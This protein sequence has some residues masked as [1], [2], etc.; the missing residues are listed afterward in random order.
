MSYARAQAGPSK[1]FYDDDVVDISGSGFKKSIPDLPKVVGDFQVVNGGDLSTLAYLILQIVK[2]SDKVVIIRAIASAVGWILND[3]INYTGSDT[4]PE[5]IT[6]LEHVFADDKKNSPE[7]LVKTN[8]ADEEPVSY[9][10]I[11]T[12]LNA[13]DDEMGSFIGLLFLAGVKQITAQNRTAFNEKR[14]KSVASTLTSAP[15]IFVPNSIYLSDRT[16]KAVYATFTSCGAIRANMLSLLIAKMSPAHMGKARSM[17]SMILLLVDSGMSGL[18]IIKEATIKYRWIVTSF[19]ELAP[20]LEAANKAFQ[21]IGAA[22]A[23]TRPFLKAIHGS[24]FVPVAYAE[25]NNLVGVCKEVLT[26]TTPSYMNYHGG[27]ANAHQK[28]IIDSYLQVAKDEPASVQ[29]E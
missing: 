25:I 9:G 20:E 28:Q 5:A 26:R 3:S 12:L 8:F 29:V 22:P 27:E 24:E 7:V 1:K 2:S 23:S 10:E 13:D 6:G 4:A 17:Y 15:L 11:W 19:P 16:L 14:A 18:K 21:V